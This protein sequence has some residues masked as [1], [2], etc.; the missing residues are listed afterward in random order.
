MW[1]ACKAW[2]VLLYGKKS[3]TTDQGGWRN[4]GSV[5]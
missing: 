4:L 2:L 1:F 5:A 3:R